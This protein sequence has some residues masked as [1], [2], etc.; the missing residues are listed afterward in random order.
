MITVCACLDVW[1]NEQYGVPVYD[2]SVAGLG[3][4]PY[5]RGATGNVATGTVSMLRVVRR[6]VGESHIC[7]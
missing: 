3:G 2:S 6:L 7:L 5:A 1:L 4:C